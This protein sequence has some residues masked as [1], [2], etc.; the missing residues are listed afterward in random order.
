MAESRLL[1]IVS[2][3]FSLSDRISVRFLVP[4][5]FRS[6]VAASSWVEWLELEE[7]KISI[8][9]LFPFLSSN[10]LKSET[11]HS[12]KTESVTLK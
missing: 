5:T 1:C 6:V 9:P 8:G 12:A 10:H 4:N 7:V 2:A 11:L 3:I